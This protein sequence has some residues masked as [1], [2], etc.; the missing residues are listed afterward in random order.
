MKAPIWQ[1]RLPDRKDDPDFEALNSSLGIDGRLFREEIAATRA[2]A[3]ALMKAG[4]YSAAECASVRNALDRIEAE[5]ASGDLGLEGFEDIHSLVETRLVELTGEAGGR[6]QTARSRNEQTVTA[7]RLFMKKAAGRIVRAIA[8][9]REAALAQAEASVDV[10]LPGYT[11]CRPAQPLRF[12][13]YLCAL[14]F[15]LERDKGRLEAAVERIDAS[16]AGTAALAG[17][18]FGLDR[19]ALADELGFGSVSGNSL[20]TVSDRDGQMELLSALAILMVRLSRLSEDLIYW[21]SPA[22]GFVDFDDAYCTSSSLMPQKKNPDGL[23]LVRGKTGRVIGDLV[24]LLVTCK[25]LPTGYQKDLQEDKAALLD[26]VDTALIC[27]DVCAGII[28]GMR[29]DSA[30]TKAAITPECMATDVADGLVK[31][32][33]PFREAFGIVAERFGAKSAQDAENADGHW[34][35]PEESVERRDVQGGTSRKAV[36][37]Q[38]AHLAGGSPK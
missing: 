15:G 32:G 33:V 18:T 12:G 28:K 9:L 31:K 34:P 2:H 8:R 22:Y 17:A 36:V 20:D 37:D 14:C 5:I 30:K 16:P 29:I 26:A 4:I 6:I 35:T 21:S 3:G 27:V 7:Q 24:S 25:G 10:L 11:H 23:E 38:I 1:C 19:A 13:H